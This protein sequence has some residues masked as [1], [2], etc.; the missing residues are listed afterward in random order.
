VSMH[1]ITNGAARTKL[2]PPLPAPTFG[3][4]ELGTG[5]CWSRVA[6][7]SPSVSSRA[8]VFLTRL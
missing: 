5:R 4:L 7:S 6:R 3:D 1:V 2:N 8:G